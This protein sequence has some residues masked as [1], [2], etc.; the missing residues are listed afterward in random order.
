VAFKLTSYVQRERDAQ[1][2]DA[3]AM[4]ILLRPGVCWTAV[5]HGH[6]FNPTI[7]R[8]GEPI[9]LLEAK[10]RKARG[11]R[12]GIPDFLLWADRKPFALERKI[13]GGVLSD[14][15]KLFQAELTDA[16]VTVATCFSQKDVLDALGEWGLLRSYT[17]TA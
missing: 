12:A 13:E 9:G 10:I 15:Q 8:N 5:D 2:Q 4:R 7:G 11:V 3:N 6:S 17:A 1:V 16:G 14:D